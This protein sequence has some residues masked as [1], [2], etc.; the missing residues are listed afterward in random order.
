MF[1]VALGFALTMVM[2]MPSV[3]LAAGNGTRQAFLDVVMAQPVNDQAAIGRTGENA[4]MYT[5]W[6]G[7]NGAW[8]G[9][10]VD[11]CARQAGVSTD[12]IPTGIASV[13]N[14]KNWYISAGRWHDY[15]YHPQPGDLVVY[16]E[17]NDAGHVGIV[18][19]VDESRFYTR[20]GN[21]GGT[22]DVVL[23]DSWKFETHATGYSENMAYIV[24]FC[25]PDFPD[26]SPIPDF[27]YGSKITL[28]EGDGI[29]TIASVLDRSLFVEVASGSTDDGA[30]V[31]LWTNDAEDQRR[32]R[33]TRNSD[34]T[35]TIASV[36]SGKVLDVSAGSKQE[37]ANVQQWSNSNVDQQHWYV[38]DCGNGFYALKARHSNGFL[39]VSGGNANLG[40]NL[41][42]YHGWSGNLSQMFIISKSYGKSVTLPT[43]DGEYEISSY[44]NRDLVVSVEGSS[45][46]N[47]G[48]IA[49]STWASEPNQ[50][51]KF[52]HNADGTYTI[53]AVHSSKVL[54]VAGYRI[55]DMTN[56]QQWNNVEADQQHWYVQAVEGKP[57][58]YALKCKYTGKFLDVSGG[59]AAEGRNIQQYHG[60]LTD[61]QC[62]YITPYH[63]YG[64]GASVYNN[65]SYYLRPYVD[66]A[67]AVDVDGSADGANVRLWEWGRQADQKF[68]FTDKGGGTYNLIADGGTRFLEVYNTSY[69]NA[70]NIEVGTGSTS[71]AR[72][73]YIHDAGWGGTFAL[74]NMASGMYLHVKNG[75]GA[76]GTNVDQALG[77]GAT[78]QRYYLTPAREGTVVSIDSGAYHL[79]NV[80]G[81]YLIA[82]DA[83]LTLSSQKDALVLNA[84]RDGTV[85]ISSG[86]AL[87]GVAR[88]DLATGTAVA[89]G[90]G[91]WEA[92]CRWYIEDAGNGL[93]NLRNAWSNLYLGIVDDVVVQT[94]Y[95]QGKAFALYINSGDT[96]TPVASVTIDQ[97]EALMTAA[98]E[99][100]KL[101]ATVLP[102]DASE[103]SVTWSSSDEAVATV[104]DDGT[105]T[106]AANGTALITATTVE[107][108]FSATCLVTVDIPEPVISVT[109]VTLDHT[110]LTLTAVGQT[111]W[112]TST[113]EPADASDPSVTWSS[114]DESVAMVSSRGQVVAV[115][116]GTATITATTT[117]GGFTSACTVTVS[118]PEVD[119]PVSVTGIRLDR[120]ALTFDKADAQAVLVATVEPEDASEKTVNWTSSNEAVAIVGSDGVVTSVSNGTAVI[121][122]TSVDGGFTADCTVTVDIPAAP[123]VVAVTGVT[124]SQSSAM[125]SSRGETLQ[126]SAVVQPDNATNKELAW[127]STNPAAAT[128]SADGLVTAVANGSS[129][130]VALTVDGNKAD[131]CAVTVDIPISVTGVTLDRNKMTLKAEGESLRLNAAVEPADADDKTVSWSTSNDAVATV[132]QTGLVTAVANGSAT[133]T[134]TTADGKYTDSCVVAVDIPAVVEPVVVTGVSLNR[135]EATLKAEGDG[136]Q[137][138][139]I[140]TPADADDRTVSWTTSDESIATVDQYGWVTAISRGVATITAATTDGGFTADCIVT[141][142]IPQPVVPVTDIAFGQTKLSFSEL[143]AQTQL[144]AFIEPP[145]ATNQAVSWISTNPPVATVSDTG[146]VTA[147]A[148]GSATIIVLTAD[149]NKT[150]TCD[151]TVALPIQPVSLESAA[152]AVAA[153]GLT[154]TGSPLKPAVTVTLEGATLAEGVDYTVS[155]AG[156]TNAGTATV[157][158]TGAGNYVGTATASF[159]IAP[160]AITPAVTLSK[161]SFVYNGKAQRPSVTVR[162]GSAELAA[163]AYAVSYA[164]GCKDVGTH[165]V[166]VTLKGNYAGSASASFDIVP[167]GTKLSKVTAASR[168]FTAKWKKQA[169]QTTGYQVQYST[170]STFKKGNKTVT[171]KGAKTVSKKVAKLKAKKVYYVRVRTYKKVGSKTHYSAWSAKK[172]VKTK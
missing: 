139:A 44:L 170:S 97:S 120:D 62:F 53:A 110:E 4:N 157:T 103:T 130:I 54:D 137:L 125:L 128:V 117:D 122:A 71:I 8:C 133:I 38:E 25:S 163:D 27:D 94:N 29:Y 17:T 83:S 77:D 140:V 168:A 156:N 75:V 61:A 2:I 166:T 162:D 40:T 141:V 138:A 11:Y 150:A 114:S 115:A 149:G 107:G 98:G 43:G 13:K 152:V 20:E 151:V 65:A 147:V 85:T 14:I 142:D 10:F 172:K 7:F 95:S 30:N 68:K 33:F 51:F 124:M 69:V 79:T 127:V 82:N 81:K 91:S 153:D 31:R 164:S 56:I 35:Y 48:N 23:D 72:R 67:Y 111:T 101:S 148:E 102:E 18:T 89:F 1:S 41:Q 129:T 46:E 70:A 134:V 49:L 58:A 161:T 118:I 131:T 36:K 52:T 144:R 26:D 16:S 3:A 106:A 19:G 9:M 87:L 99:T 73:W 92:G 32:W 63:H 104:S 136:V 169:T 109:G 160:K 108:N 171:V 78:S 66:P 22:K 21:R 88:R 39:D 116:N 145:D 24:G 55:D 76:N 126:L 45:T 59:N 167:K 15:T 50:R 80:K 93:Y 28:P 132:D 155:Y 135:T 6:Y 57:H 112:L 90:D 158:V 154:Y 47:G 37:G 143:G 34:G 123:V 86:D 113:V 5:E 12:V 84:Q 96:H 64:S 60:N 105:V 121:T 159:A 100:L 74:R 165:K 119:V 146:L 42:Q